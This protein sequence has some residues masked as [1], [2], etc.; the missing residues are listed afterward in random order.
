MARFLR[1]HSIGTWGSAGVPYKRLDMGSGPSTPLSVQRRMKRL[2]LWLSWTSAG[3]RDL[4]VGFAALAPL[5]LRMR[6]AAGL[7]LNLDKTTIANFGTIANDELHAELREPLSF[8]TPS[9]SAAGTSLGFVLTPVYLHI[10]P[11]GLIAAQIPRKGSFV[12]QYLGGR[13]IAY[14]TLAFSML[15]Y[16]AQVHEPCVSILRMEAASWPSILAAPMYA[17]HPDLLVDL[18][19]LGSRSRVPG[20]K[21]ARPRR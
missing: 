19:L 15:R 10:S 21:S 8:S 9:V 14:T 6:L 4:T 16:R 2:C 7:R 12:P 20:R 18:K 11:M 13:L 1:R 5:L 3:V 17:F